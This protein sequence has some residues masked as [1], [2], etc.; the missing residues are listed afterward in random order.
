MSVERLIITGGVQRDGAIWMKEF[1]HYQLAVLAEVDLRTGAVRRLMEYESPPAVCAPQRPSIVFKCASLKGDRLYLCTQTE[2]LVLAWPSLQRLAYHSLPSF[3]DLHHVHPLGDELLV[4][5]TGLDMVIRLDASGAPV[6]FTSVLGEDPWA[7]FS[8]ATDYRR[9]ASTKPHVAH[10]NYVFFIDGEPWVSRCEKRDAVRLADP[11][12]HI[13]VEVERIHDGDVMDGLAWFTT[14]NGHVVTADPAARRVEQVWN[15]ASL[16]D[17]DQPLGW[18]RGICRD[19]D[20]TY[21]GFSRIRPTKLHDNLRWV[22]NLGKSRGNLPTRIGVYDLKAG[23]HV[24]DIDLEGIGL[25][26]VFSVIGV[27]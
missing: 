16:T 25:A 20:L 6:A 5:S 11:T 23:R 7:R 27:G 19:G 17:T 21:V 13:P 3:N 4:V 12:D 1:Q 24:R 8:P 10:P 15:L 22:K 2:V 26:A 14:V 9:V 18:C